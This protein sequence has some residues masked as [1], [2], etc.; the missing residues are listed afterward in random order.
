ME[1]YSVKA[2]VNFYLG[3]IIINMIVEDGAFLVLRAHNFLKFDL[4]HFTLAY[5]LVY[6]VYFKKQNLLLDCKPSNNFYIVGLE[7][8]LI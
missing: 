6:L 1:S 5:H 8:I 7:R 2:S 4:N 3:E